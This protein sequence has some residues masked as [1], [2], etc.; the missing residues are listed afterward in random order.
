MLDPTKSCIVD[1][2]PTT[3]NFTL[4]SVFACY[5][6]CYFFGAVMNSFYFV[7]YFH[8]FMDRTGEAARKAGLKDIACSECIEGILPTWLAEPPVLRE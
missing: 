4:G 6:M 7:P 3:N 1:Y 2:F 5:V 8:A